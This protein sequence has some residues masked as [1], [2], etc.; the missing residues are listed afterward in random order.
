[1]LHDPAHRLV[2]SRNNVPL[3]DRRTTDHVDRQSEQPGSFDLRIGGVAP[4]ILCENAR[5]AVLAEKRHIVVRPEWTTRRDDRRVRKLGRRIG[6]INDANDVAMLRLRTKRQDGGTSERREDIRRSIRKGSNGLFDVVVLAPPIAA[7]LFPRRPLDSKQRDGGHTASGDGVCADLRRERM[8]RVD[9]EIDALA[10]EINGQ[11][12]RAAETADADRERTGSGI[13]RSSSQRQRC[14][15]A[16]NGRQ[17]LR[18][19]RRFARAAE[20]QNLEW[21]S[22]SR[23]HDESPMP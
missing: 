6:R 2:G 16:R 4:G 8:R 21:L 17:S 18:N 12:I 13:A 20:Q 1:M 5:N 3:N 19:Q 10:F 23:I 14:R 11:P 9:D 7:G 15:Y 22:R